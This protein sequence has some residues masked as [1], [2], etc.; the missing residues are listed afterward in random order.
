VFGFRDQ[1]F[2]EERL[3]GLIDLEVDGFAILQKVGSYLPIDRTSQ[4]M[5]N[6]SATTPM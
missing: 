2:Q 3:F 5:T 1:A 6:E 4:P